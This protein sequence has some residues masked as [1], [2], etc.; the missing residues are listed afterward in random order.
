[1][2]Y[3]RVEKRIGKRGSPFLNKK[4]GAFQTTFSLRSNHAAL[5][6]FQSS[7]RITRDIR[8]S[9]RLGLHPNFAPFSRK[10]SYIPNVMP[11]S[12]RSSRHNVPR[13]PAAVLLVANATAHNS[14]Y[15]QCLSAT[16]LLPATSHQARHV[17][18]N[19]KNFYNKGNFKLFF[20]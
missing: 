10:T 16:S 7:G 4:T 20:P 18:R 19:H 9:S 2:N 3:Q 14:A 17:V 1:M 6:S 8:F 12:L 11:P 5:S 15:A 13:L